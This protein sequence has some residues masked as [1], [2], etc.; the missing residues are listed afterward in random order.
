M[1]SPSGQIGPKLHKMLFKSPPL[2]CFL[3]LKLNISFPNSDVKDMCRRQKKKWWNTALSLSQPLTFAFLSFRFFRLSYPFFFLSFSS[4]C[5]LLGCILVGN[6]FGKI[7]GIIRLVWKSRSGGW[8]N[9]SC[10]RC[11]FFLLFFTAC[12]N[13]TCPFKIICCL[14]SDLKL[15]PW[16]HKQYKGH[17]QISSE[18][19]K[20]YKE[21]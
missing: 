2:C 1:R 6:I 16:C 13:E 12:L 19:I 21:S 7:I 17:V 5:H 9:T 11:Y 14:W 20:H 8:W 3:F 4:A 18:W 10:I 15:M